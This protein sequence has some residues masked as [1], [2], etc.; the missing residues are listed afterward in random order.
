MV[1]DR[2][3]F[4]PLPPFSTTVVGPPATRTTPDRNVLPNGSRQLF[5][6]STP[7]PLRQPTMSLSDTPTEPFTQEQRAWLETRLPP[8]PT[9]GPAAS[10]QAGADPSSSASSATTPGEYA[11]GGGGWGD[12]SCMF[13]A[14]RRFEVLV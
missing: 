14:E 5:H 8:P 10:D 11:G 3:Y 13:A 4:W 7:R 12:C 9:A 1:C 6:T 2:N